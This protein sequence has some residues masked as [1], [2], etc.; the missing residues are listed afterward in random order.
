MPSGVTNT[1]SLIRYVLN[2]NTGRQQHHI[3]VLECSP[4]LTSYGGM[5]FY[6]PMI[7]RLFLL[8]LPLG[9]KYIYLNCK[10]H[11]AEPS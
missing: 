5:D 6:F 4:E 7:R 1:N 11:R 10:P 3:Y 8:H 9:G 2:A